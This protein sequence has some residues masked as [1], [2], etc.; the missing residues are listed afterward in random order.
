MSPRATAH[1]RQLRLLD[2][3]SLLS[4]ALVIL[5][6]GTVPP[7]LHAADPLP[8]WN[9]GPAKKAILAFVTRVTDE[10]DKDFIPLAERIAVFDNDGTLW[11]ENPVP[12]QLAFALDGLK[13]LIA[14]KPEATRDPYVNA[15][16]SGDITKLLADHY[17][18][19]FHIIALTHAGITAKEFATRV[20]DWMRAA[21]HPR[22]G[23]P[24][25]DCVYR[26]MRE[27]LAYLRASGFKTFIVSGGGA[28]FMRAWSERVYGIPPEQVVGSHAQVTYE[29]R[30]GQ[31][32][33]VKT[34]DHVF[35]DDGE[36][37]PV[38]I[39][40]FVGRQPV[41][42]FGNSDGDKAMLE[43][44]T[45]GNPRPSL[46][47][48]VHHTDADREYAYDAEPKSTGRLVEALEDAPKRGWVVIDMKDDW[49]QVLSD[50]SVTA[51][52]ILLEPDGTM[53]E[54]AAATNARLREGDPRG[55][56]L[57]ARHRPHIT[58]VQ[59]FVRTADLVKV[60]TAAGE[61]LDGV[62]VQDMML[63]A[64]KY[65]Y[66]P[67]GETGLAG[68]LIEP[69][70]DL[71]KLQ[72]NLIQAIAPYAVESG[73]SDAFVTTPDDLIMNRALIDY[74]SCFV[75]K[76]AGERYN[77]HVTTGVGP[78]HYLDEMVR[79]PFPSFTFSPAGAAVYQLGQYGTAAKQLKEWRLTR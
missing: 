40:Q 67:D 50:P 43:Y 32:V 59:R 64:F 46:G 9:E 7:R 37:K 28:D 35:V 22:Y 47:L 48:I 66:I 5:A 71:V 23:R 34:L 69:T 63:K 27:V 52:D 75:P 56:R 2:H 55:F 19:L 78:R 10:G 62:K 49:K 68:I 77:P 76:A 57:D 79:E 53:L 24:Y 17:K 3:R 54:R 44:T 20:D 6:I 58:L 8:A 38:G 51:I 65:Y 21:K 16:L 42:C 11:P 31:P 14:T 74:V 33:L 72:Q 60:Y 36:G 26:P 30:D 13:R 12:F 45:I 41:L 25:D 4:V 29:L 61:V 1:L 70:P 18:G 15:A 39:H 73:T